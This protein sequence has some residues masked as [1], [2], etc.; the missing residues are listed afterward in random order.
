MGVESMVG[1]HLD[2]RHLSVSGCNWLQCGIISLIWSPGEGDSQL[3][4]SVWLFDCISIDAKL[5]APG[6]PHAC[7]LLR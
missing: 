4:P 2:Q 5:S 6:A 1:G 3:P 7:C